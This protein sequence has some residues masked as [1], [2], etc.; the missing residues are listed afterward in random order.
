MAE[1]GLQGPVIGV[2]FDGTGY[3]VDGHI[4]GGEFLL[5]DYGGFRRLA[6]FEEFP[7][8]GGDQAIKEPW[9]VAAACLYRA[10]G[11]EMDWLELD[12]V[13]R[14]ANNKRWRVVRQ[15][16]AKRVNAPL[17]S[18]VGR[19]FD[20]AAALL[21]LRDQTEFEAQAAIALE[22]V[23]GEVPGGQYPFRTAQPGGVIV[24]ET[25]EFFRALVRD[26]Q[27]GVPVPHIAASFHNTLAQIVVEVCRRIRRSNGQNNVALS[28]GVFQ[29]VR[30]LT[31]TVERLTQEGFHTYTHSRVPPNDGGIALGQI[32]VAGALLQ[33]RPV[34]ALAPCA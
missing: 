26:I 14:L 3:G 19:L 1:N 23:A 28:G 34:E 24:I 11:D 18:S 32:A 16:I 5:A 31:G 30:L 12:F 25:A 13:S 20:A 17:T 33:H 10:Y 15:M 22:V 2:A 27:K 4:W 8:P 7:L 21:G 9:R 6:H 29:N